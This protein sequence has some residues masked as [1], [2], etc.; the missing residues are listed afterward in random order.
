MSGRRARRA[1]AGAAGPPGILGP[2]PI[3]SRPLRHRLHAHRRP[4]RRRAR[5][6]ARHQ[7]RLR[8]AGRA[9][10]LLASTG[11]PTPASS[12]TSPTLWGGDPEASE[13]ERRGS[14]STRCIAALRRAAA[15][16]RSTS[17]ARSETLPGI[18]ELVTALAADRRALVGLLTGNVLEGARLKL[19]PTG[20]LLALQG[21]R[22][23]LRLGAARRPA[24]R[25]RRP[26]RGADGPPLRRQG[27]RRHR[28]HAGRRRV[29]RLAR[30]HRRRRG[31][32]PARRGRARRARA[33]PPVR[34]PLGLARG[35]RRHHRLA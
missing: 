25:R 33:G 9:R 23:R 31:H 21:R 1:P 27:R 12:A 18:R 35:L 22:L 20:L 11:A 4:R 26:R 32:R 29:R 10:R 30:G 24:G 8:R 17:A 6:P 19:E 16:R 15:R 34:R 2:C 7:G 28:R 13:L 14:Q 5:D 3:A